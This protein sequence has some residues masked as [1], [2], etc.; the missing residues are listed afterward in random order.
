M[1]KN[2]GNIANLMKA[3][4]QL[5]ERAAKLKQQMEATRIRGR[6]CEGDHQ[7]TVEVSGLG[8]VHEVDISSSLFSPEHRSL[9]Q[10][11][12]LEATNHAVAQAK[13]M[14]A[15]SIRELTQGVDIPGLEKVIQDMTQ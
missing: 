15:D 10:R 1:F 6:A 2:L 12:T 9:A 14:H 7:V 4:G 8:Q 5:P 11:L 3:F 13:L